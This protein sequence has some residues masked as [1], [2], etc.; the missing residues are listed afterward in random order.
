MVLKAMCG[1][2]AAGAILTSSCLSL[3]LR[4]FKHIY[5]SKGNLW[6][7]DALDTFLIST[8]MIVKI[9]LL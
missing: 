2:N 9:K 6:G 5:G 1:F 3:K 7:F 8:S 4:Y